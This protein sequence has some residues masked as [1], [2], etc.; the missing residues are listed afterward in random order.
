MLTL[1][2]D[3]PYDPVAAADPGL[4]VVVA[5]TFPDTP[6]DVRAELMAMLDSLRIT[7]APAASPA[8]DEAIA[9]VG[10]RPFV[11]TA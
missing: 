3:Q 10:R 2:P 9:V 8:A 6:P 1:P 4:L 5:S 7:P 11:S